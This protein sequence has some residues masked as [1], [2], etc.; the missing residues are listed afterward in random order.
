[1]R[2]GVRVGYSKSAFLQIVAEIEHGAA[3]KERALGI[4]HDPNIGRMNHDIARGGAFDEIHFVL[5]AG[6]AAPDHSQA[7][8]TLWPALFFEERA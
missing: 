6:A 8:R 3:D 1:M 2:D 7:Q 5:Q 4:D